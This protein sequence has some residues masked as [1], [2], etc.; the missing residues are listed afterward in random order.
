LV[1]FVKRHVCITM[2]MQ[3]SGF[4]LAVDISPDI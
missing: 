1:I 4:W 2:S 3:N